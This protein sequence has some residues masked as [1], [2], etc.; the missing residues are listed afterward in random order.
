MDRAKIEIYQLQKTP[1]KGIL[2]KRI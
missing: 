2:N 1:L